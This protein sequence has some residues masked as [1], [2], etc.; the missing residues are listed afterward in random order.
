MF[1]FAAPRV[2]FAVTSAETVVGNR[3]AHAPLVAL[4]KEQAASFS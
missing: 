1:R 2:R 3:C 4:M